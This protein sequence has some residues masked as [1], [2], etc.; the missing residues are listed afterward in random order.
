MAT[1]LRVVP[2][3]ILDMRKDHYLLLL[4]Q[5]RLTA[6]EREEKARDR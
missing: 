4:A 1:E 2:Q 3:T 6:K 5:Y